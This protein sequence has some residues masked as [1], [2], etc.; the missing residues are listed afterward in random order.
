MGVWLGIVKIRNQSSFFN[1]QTGRTAEM[2][3]TNPYRTAKKAASPLPAGSFLF[4]VP[5]GLTTDKRIRIRSMHP[6]Y[7][8]DVEQHPPGEPYATRFRM[9]REAGLPIPQI[10]HLFAFKPDRTDHLS[11]FTQQVMR[12]P[13]PLPPWQRELIAA[14]T[15]KL[16]Q[17]LF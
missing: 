6:M 9:M 7:L 8:Q 16:N 13:S 1:S 4:V 5:A 14:F 17:C 3:G 15:S 2:V 10:Q 12:G 11:R